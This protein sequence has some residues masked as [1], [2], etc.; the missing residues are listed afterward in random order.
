MR[1]AKTRPTS[2]RPVQLLPA[3]VLAG[4]V[5]SAASAFGQSTPR[6]DAVS[7]GVVLSPGTANAVVP[8]TITRT[9]TT[10][11][12]GASVT[13]QLSTLDLVG[14]ALGGFLG[15]TGANPSGPY[16]TNN[17]GGSFT[18]DGVTL[19]SPCG[20]SAQNGVVFNVTVGS[21]ATSGSGTLTI[22]QVK[23]RDC[24]NVTIPSTIG[25]VA[26]VEIDRTGPAITQCAPNQPG[27]AGAACQAAVPNFTASV[28]ATDP[29]GPITVTQSPTAGSLVGLG[30]T[31]VTL[32]ASDAYGNT[33]TCTATFTVSDQTPPQISGAPTNMTV[34]TGTGA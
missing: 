7:P 33:S 21:S 22:T 9:S 10:P 29:H 25:S 8:I 2:G 1:P 28:V 19:G 27:G 5:L 23:L 18:V 17:G 4:V 15:A 13:F 3:L 11:I 32:T 16:V 31:L 34:F 6:V 30:P 26:T 14:T 24:S 20:S 12:S